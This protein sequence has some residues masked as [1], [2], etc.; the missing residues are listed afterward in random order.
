MSAIVPYA[1]PYAALGVQSLSGAK[2]VRTAYNAARHVYQHR[3]NYGRA[4]KAAARAA[5]SGYKAW[6]RSRNAGLGIRTERTVPDTTRQF[7]Q[8]APT[9]AC[10][11]QTL[12]A[13]PIKLPQKNTYIGA[14]SGNS[15]NLSGIKF[16]YEFEN[17]G[18]VPIELH[19]A[20][21]QCKTSDATPMPKDKFFR[22][23]T[24]TATRALDF[25]DQT[26]AAPWEFSYKCLPINPEQYRIFFH[27]KRVL[28]RRTAAD[29]VTSFS[30]RWY[31]HINEYLP[32]QQNV[33]FNDDGD[34]FGGMNPVHFVW[35]FTTMSDQNWQLTVAANPKISQR[36]MH[37]LYYRNGAS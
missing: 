27:R 26:D 9:G 14:R 11:A 23:S 5:K 12:Y 20:L 18:A 3:D 30:R 16:C 21:I 4:A 29:G 25:T 37:Q 13:V 28:G 31:W 22:D 32:W 33:S 24:Q 15:I 1:A 34:E 10:E 6:G 17:Q 8:M 7:G 36:H 19:F 2:R 35:W